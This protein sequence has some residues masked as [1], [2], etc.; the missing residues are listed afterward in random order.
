MRDAEFLAPPVVTT[1]QSARPHDSTY[2]LM[3]ATFIAA[4]LLLA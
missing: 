4:E 1:D 3:T 2:R